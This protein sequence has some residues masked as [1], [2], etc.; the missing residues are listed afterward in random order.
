M[1]VKYLDQSG[2]TSF[3]KIIRNRYD[4]AITG[5]STTLASNKFSISFTPISGSVITKTLEFAGSGDSSVNVVDGKVQI[6]SKNPSVP[7]QGATG[8]LGLTGTKVTVLDSKMTKGTGTP[9]QSNTNLAQQGYVDQKVAEAIAGGIHWKGT[10]ETL[11]SSPSNGDMYKVIKSITIASGISQDSSAHTATLGD[12]I[13]A[14]VDS[15]NNTKWAYI[16]SADDVEYTGIKTSGTSVTEIISATKGGDAIF[17]AG[18]GLSVAGASGN[19]TYS[20]STPSGAATISTASLKKIKTDSFGH[21]TGTAAVTSGDVSSIAVTSIATKTGAITLQTSS[22]VNGAV[23]LG[24]NGQQLSGTVVG[25]KSAAFTESSAYEPKF[26]DGSAVIATF[27]NT[28]KKVTL[29][30]GI[31]Q[32][33]GKISNSTESDIILEAVA[34]TGKASD[35]TVVSSTTTFSSITVQTALEELKSSI[36]AAASGGVTKFG[37][38]TGEITVQSTTTAGSVNFTMSNNQLTGSVAGWA[39][40]ANAATTLGGYGI[41]DA[42]TK[43]EVGTELSKKVDKLTTATSGDIV[44]FG[45]SG[46]VADSGKVFSTVAPTSTSTDAQVPTSKAVY[47]AL[48]SKANSSAIPTSYYSKVSQAGYAGTETA[49]AGAGATLTINSITKAELA[50]ILGVNE[51]EL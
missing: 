33:N 32:T 30:A 14:S 31:T 17:A 36:T 3:W 47:T 11:P 44:T 41:T 26:T 7:V 21:V 19:V 50:S 37:G 40:K 42:Y 51:S 34:K 38:K 45:T 13:I 2:L 12:V 23:N 16:P 28:T 4:G 43:T 8:Y 27:N 35:V 48:S 25:L 39:N 15:S 20:H 24:M 6:Y 22:T 46:A 9:Y 29:K 5:V 10:T 18:N 49:T 1:A